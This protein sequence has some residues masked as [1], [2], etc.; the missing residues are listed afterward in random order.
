MKSPY[1]WDQVISCKSD[2]KKYGRGGG[3]IYRYIYIDIPCLLRLN[4]I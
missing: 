1:V 2:Y 4:D 3:G